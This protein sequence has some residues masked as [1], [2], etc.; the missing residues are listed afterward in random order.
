MTGIAERNQVLF[1]VIASM[2]AKLLVVDFQIR[3]C[4]A[5]LTAPRVPA[6]HLLPQTLVRH[7]IK[8]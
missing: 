5:C 8:A 1:R 3:H 4:S 7:G 2:A 6:Q